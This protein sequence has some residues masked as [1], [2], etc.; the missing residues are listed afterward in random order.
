MCIIMITPNNYDSYINDHNCWYL[1]NS[2]DISFNN[3]CFIFNLDSQNLLNIRSNKIQTPT[4]DVVLTK[5]EA[6]LQLKT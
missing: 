4:D 3:K 5:T 2:N 6:I 1:F